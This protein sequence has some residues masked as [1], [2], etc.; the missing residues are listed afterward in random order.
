MT[1]NET[2]TLSNSI[3]LEVDFTAI[4]YA[5]GFK[6]PTWLT[7]HIDGKELRTLCGKDGTGFFAVTEDDVEI[8]LIDWLSAHLKGN[9]T[10][11]RWMWDTYRTARVA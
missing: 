4:E 2:I 6:G 8:A 11:F 7:A 1:T 5:D 9:V 3:G 10:S